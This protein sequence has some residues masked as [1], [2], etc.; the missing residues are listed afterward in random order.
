MTRLFR[1]PLV[2]FLVLGAAIFALFAAFDD[3]PV[4]AANDA[5]VVTEEDIADLRQNFENIW[6]RVPTESELNGLVARYVD[7]EVLL[8]S[9][10]ALGLDHDDVVIRQ[11]LVQKMKFIIESGG[12]STAPEDED[13]E[14]HLAAYPD[15]FEQAGRVAFEQVLLRD[16]V[17][18]EALGTALRAGAL[19]ADMV[20][21]SLLPGRMAPSPASVV[22]GT[23][24]AGFFGTLAG[25]DKDGWTGPVTSTYGQHVVRILAREGAVLPPLDAIRA[26]VEVD[27]RANKQTR[28]A[29]E[30]LD[31]LKSGFR[32]VLP[33]PT[34]EPVK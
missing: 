28:M 11:R 5:I 7:D 12:T 21:V 13:L 2:H 32:I 19:P 6:F 10:K 1:E 33:T 20:A 23:F 22:D 18:V 27:W 17:S 29:Q 30:R 8:R 31:I 24:G 26:E 9:A 16:G 14:A 25:L 4:T 34:V 3:T 15:R